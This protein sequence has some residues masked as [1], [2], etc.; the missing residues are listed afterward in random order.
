MDLNHRL[1]FR[2]SVELLSPV[3]ISLGCKAKST[4]PPR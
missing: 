3:V 4:G 1:G 2:L